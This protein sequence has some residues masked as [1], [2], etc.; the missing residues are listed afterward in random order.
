MKENLLPLF[1]RAESNALEYMA[2]HA[3]DKAAIRQEK[4]RQSRR[5]VYFHLQYHPEN[6][7]STTNQR[8]WKEYVSAPEGAPPLNQMANM[9]GELVGID[10]LTIAYS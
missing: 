7:N 4:Q 6:P 2:R 5:Q 9:E 3:E 8:L 10:K 1:S